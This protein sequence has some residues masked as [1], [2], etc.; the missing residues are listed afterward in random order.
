MFLTLIQGSKANY[1]KLE[2]LLSKS[3]P[4][5]IESG[6]TLASE[7]IEKH[8]ME[9]KLYL[10]RAKLSF[11]LVRLENQNVIHNLHILFP[12]LLSNSFVAR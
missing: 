8:E 3:S 10:L 9:A 1:S 11:K 5:D 4:S 12:S 7:A 2:E 6:I